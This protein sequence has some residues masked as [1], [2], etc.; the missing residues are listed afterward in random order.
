MLWSFFGNSVF[1]I[2]AQ[3]FCRNQLNQNF[4]MQMGGG[5]SLEKPSVAEV[6]PVTSNT[7]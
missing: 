2:I 5:E 6:F 3:M 7:S 4:Q 1:A